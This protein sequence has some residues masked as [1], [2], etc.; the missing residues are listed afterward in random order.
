MFKL[1]KTNQKFR[2]LAAA[3]FVSEVGSWF[4]YML[5]IVLT[6][7]S[8]K[9]LLTTMGVTGSLSIGS[10]IGGAVAGVFIENKRPVKVIVTTNIVSAIGI[11]S[12]YF[13]PNYLW[14]YFIAAFFLALVS[15]FRNPAFN[16]FIVDIVDKENLMDANATFQ[17]TRELVKIIGPGLAATVLA[18]LPE[19][20]KNLGFVI[21]AVTY[22]IAST[23]LMGVLFKNI[24][25]TKISVE[26]NKNTQTFWQRWVEGLAPAKSPVIISIL[27]MYVFIMFGIAGVDVTFTAHVNTSGYEAEFVGYI[28]GALSCGMILTSIFGSKY[29]KKLSLHVQLGGAT[30]GLGLFYMGIGL[31][32]SLY[33]MMVSAF[34]LGIF[35]STFNISASTFWQTAI[36]YDQ[37]GRFFSVITSF[38]ST[39]TLIG[40]GLNGFIGTI[41][42]ASFVI[43]ICGIMILFS[44]VI[45]LFVIMRLS[46]E[47]Q[48]EVLEEKVN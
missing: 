2:R 48:V 9:S 38:L 28:L 12:L 47:D 42:S 43:L 45:S 7:S 20:E 26:K 10:L 24:E 32:G 21:D 18:V 3:L 25:G 17:T 16:K 1:V 22:V 36:P 5:L 39:I 23:F 35:N 15:S 37:L 27:M 8:T 19:S 34:F 4:S 44:G 40:M 14:I 33:F 6:Y 13:L 29:I 11:C 31:S 41:S 46:E 30:A